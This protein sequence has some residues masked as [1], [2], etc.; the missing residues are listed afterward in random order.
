MR[1]RLMPSKAECSVLQPPFSSIFLDSAVPLNR[2][3]V[4]MGVA[5]CGKSTVGAAIAATEGLPLV[6]GDHFHSQA[7]R[8]KM[9]RGIPL[10]DADR[11]QW[12]VVL[13][14]QLKAHPDGVVLTCSALKRAYRDRL[15][16]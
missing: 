3:L 7:S 15:R 2:R 4:C 16:A 11:A 9:A 5:G 1:D 6:E 14:E 13:G 8:D 12:L 10:G